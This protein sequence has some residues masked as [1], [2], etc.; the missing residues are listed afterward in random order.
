MEP[1]TL[2]VIAGPNG[3]GKSSLVNETGLA[4]RS[5][6]I[7]NPDNYAWGLAEGHP[8]IAD[9]YLVAVRA[10]EVLRDTLL[11]LG[12]PFGIETVASR[13]DKLDLVRKAKEQG[14]FIDLIFV[15]AGSPEI[16]CRRICERV[17]RGGHDVPREKVFSRFEGT[18]GFLPEYIALADHAEVWDN[19]GESLV[20][21]LT[22]EDGE[23]RFTEAGRSLQWVSVYLSELLRFGTILCGDYGTAIC[24]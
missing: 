14:Y 15:T 24:T 13:R 16:C 5:G 9:R 8:D 7:I 18:M 2:L 23:I 6:R 17:V 11:E 1:K 20:L 21:V 4:E 19:S 3:F 12:E 22:K 10:C